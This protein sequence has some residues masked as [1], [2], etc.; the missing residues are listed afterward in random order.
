MAH[1]YRLHL[2]TGK[3]V[4]SFN[5]FSHIHVPKQY[6]NV[7]KLCLSACQFKSRTEEKKSNTDTDA[8]NDLDYF[9]LYQSDVQNQKRPMSV[10]ESEDKTVQKIF[11]KHLFETVKV[12]VNVE[13]TGYG[14]VRYDN[15]IPK[16]EKPKKLTRKEKRMQKGTTGINT[17][18]FP[19]L[20]AVFN[21]KNESFIDRKDHAVS[22]TLDE[23]LTNEDENFRKLPVNSESDM[24]FIDEQYFKNNDGIESNLLDHK[25]NISKEKL[26]EQNNTILNNT[27]NSHGFEKLAQTES[28]ENFNNEQQ[29]LSFVDE[30]FFGN[31]NRDSVGKS[32]ENGNT[33]DVEKLKQTESAENLCKNEQ[34]LGFVDEQYFN[35]NHISSDVMPPEIKGQPIIKKLSRH[36]HESNNETEE[37]EGIKREDKTVKKADNVNKSKNK[38]FSSESSQSVLDASMKIRKELEKERGSNLIGTYDP[39]EYDSEGF[40]ILKNQVPHFHN[41]PSIDVINVLRRSIVYDDNDILALSKP[42]G[43]PSFDGPANTHSIGNFLNE[44]IPNTQLLPVHRLDKETTGVILFAKTKEMQERLKRRFYTR[45][46]VKKYLVITK[47]IPDMPNGEID[48]PIAEGTVEGRERMCLRPYD[49]PEF[50]AIAKKRQP[51]QIAITKYNVLDQGQKCA[52]LECFPLTGKKHQIRVHLAFGLNC[53]ILGD[54]KYSHINKI[55]PMKLHPEILHKL[56][57]RQTKVRYLAMHLHARSIAIPE[58]LDGKNLFIKA[59]VP[60]HFVRNMRDLK[61]KFPKHI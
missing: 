39:K 60:P 46:I 7:R 2:F 34:D 13:R 49:N 35:S 61:L 52:L 28:A 5:S 26:I 53:P 29:D 59:P 58:F 20:L 47:N 10:S 55:S 31:Y 56:R 44:I 22:V 15:S 38:N 40:R 8:E 21:E 6:K 43:I 11:R 54:H 36:E 32:S 41:A 33:Y 19:K 24:S 23:Q 45:E 57:I 18:A 4:F 48:I 42:Y 25:G 9:G 37:T 51:G 27:A 30:Q 17:Y 3:I 12:N 50:R 16:S 1:V 14:S